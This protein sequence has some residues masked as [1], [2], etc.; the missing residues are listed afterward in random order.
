MWPEVVDACHHFEA[1]TGLSG[2][3]SELRQQYLANAILN[4]PKKDHT[5]Q[6]YNEVV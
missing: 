3:S 5:G 2:E 6:H 4:M 1:L